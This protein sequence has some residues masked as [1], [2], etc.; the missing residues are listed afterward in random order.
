MDVSAYCEEI[1]GKYIFK[2]ARSPIGLQCVVSRAWSGEHP[3]S[4]VDDAFGPRERLGCIPKEKK[5]RSSNPEPIQ[6]ASSPG[7][8]SS[9]DASAGAASA[10][11]HADGLTA[12]RLAEPGLPCHALLL[13]AENVCRRYQKQVGLLPFAE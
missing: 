4:F 5:I 8:A 2:N 6:D 7:A 10:A 13:K 11:A 9:G 12:T 3:S 1:V